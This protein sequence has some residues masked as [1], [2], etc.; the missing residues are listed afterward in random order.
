MPIITINENN[1]S[2]RFIL[3]CLGARSIMLHSCDK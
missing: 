1:V 2:V 3:S